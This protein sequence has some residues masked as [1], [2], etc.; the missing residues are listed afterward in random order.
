MTQ[1]VQCW[2]GNSALEPFND[3]YL[4]CPK[5]ATL[6]SKTIPEGIDRVQ[7][8]DSDF[9]GEQYWYSHQERDHGLPNIQA[10]ARADL[11]ERCVYWLQ[12]LLQYKQPPQRVLELGSAHGAFVALLKLAGYDATGNELSP[13]IARYARET[14]GIPM[15]EGTLETQNLAAGS[16]DVVVLMDVLEHLPDPLRTM[17]QA[18]KLLKPD[19]ILLIQTPCLP[20]KATY[21]SLKAGNHPFL[22]MM[23]PGEHS[24]LFSKEA[25]VDL[26]ARLGCPYIQFEEAIFAQY[27]MFFVVSRQPIAALD[28]QTVE[29][30]LTSL[31][32]TEFPGVRIALAMIDLRAQLQ[33]S[34]ADR[35]ARLDVINRLDQMLR[36]EQQKWINLTPLRKLAR[37]AYTRI[38][39]PE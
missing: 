6:V 13:S 27:D 39:K 21:T 28:W 22:K 26:F 17:G 16:F 19:G 4:Y 34:E 33:I 25:A 3:D 11:P 29:Q 1:Q 14:F 24:F 38:I 36:E 15:L 8:G 31:P 12:T 7:D 30:R 23:L 10:R 20:E 37:R 9:Y 5:H 2:C 35:A 32:S 18:V